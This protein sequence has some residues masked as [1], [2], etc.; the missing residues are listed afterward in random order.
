MDR[1]LRMPWPHNE[2]AGQLSRT[3]WPYDGYT[4]EDQN[5]KTSRSELLFSKHFLRQLHFHYTLSEIFL[6]SSY[7]HELYQAHSQ[8]Q[9]NAKSHHSGALKPSS[10]HGTVGKLHFSVP[11]YG[12]LPPKVQRLA[13]FIHALY[14]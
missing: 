2:F 14:T 12:A 4:E 3:P 9:M 6:T 13:R 11:T 7:T 8:E 10:I 1:M 5:T